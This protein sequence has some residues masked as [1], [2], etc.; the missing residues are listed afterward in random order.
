MLIDWLVVGTSQA[1]SFVSAWT[2]TQNPDLPVTYARLSEV[3][4]LKDNYQ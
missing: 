4:N 1:N 2:P 3:L